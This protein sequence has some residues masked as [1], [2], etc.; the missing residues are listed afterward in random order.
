[1]IVPPNGF[2]GGSSAISLDRRVERVL[3][4]EA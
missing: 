1:V 3:L 2:F 4:D